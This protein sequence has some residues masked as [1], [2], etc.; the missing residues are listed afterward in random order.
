MSFEL[1]AA[2]DLWRTDQLLACGLNSRAIAQLVRG[3]ELDRLRRGTYAR[4]EWWRG[5]GPTTRRRQLVFAHALGTLTTS[6]G[7]FVYSHVSGAS[8]Q[9][10]QL[11]KG[12]GWRGQLGP[13]EPGRDG[14]DQ[15]H[16]PCLQVQ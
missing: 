3:A 8:L 4:P 7:G 1:P 13:G 15:S 6:A 2:A 14:P 9:G 12:P 10:L 11:W 16:P 5:L